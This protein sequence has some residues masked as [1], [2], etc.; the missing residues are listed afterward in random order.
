MAGRPSPP[1]VSVIICTRDRAPAVGRS[2]E[3][4]AAAAFASP[5]ITVDLVIVDNGSTDGTREVLQRWTT[6]HNL[7]TTIVDEPSPGLARARNAA[8]RLVKGEIIAM[9]DDDCVM[10]RDYFTRVVAA[11]SAVEPSI[12]GGRVE[13]GDPLDLPITI[14]TGLEKVVYKLGRKPGGFVMG[15]NLTMHRAVVDKVGMFDERFGAGAPYVAA[16]DTDYILRASLAGFPVVYDPSF[17]VEHFHGRR[18]PED[19][20]RLQQ[21][22]CFGDG[23]LYA[24]HMFGSLIPLKIITAMIKNA[25]RERTTRNSSAL[26]RR[27]HGFQLFHAMRGLAAYLVAYDRWS[28]DGRA[29]GRSARGGR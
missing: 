12:I 6:S 14:K 11:H 29:L 28:T 3:S 8:L 2:L 17:A 18:A 21:G 22:Y 10:A 20:R 13:L 25:T 16:E 27:P 1:S 26:I 7:A 15:A 5:D 24:K 4:L 19:G 23:A 9:T